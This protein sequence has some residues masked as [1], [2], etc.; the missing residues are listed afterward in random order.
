VHD[1]PKKG[2]ERLQILS[3]ELTF[4]ECVNILH[5]GRLIFKFLLT[6]KVSEYSNDNELFKLSKWL[7]E[8][9]GEIKV[10]LE[11]KEIIYEGDNAS[12]REQKLKEVRNE[13]E[14]KYRSELDN[15]ITEQ[16]TFG[17]HGYTL[18]YIKNYC[19][20]LYQKYDSLISKEQNRSLLM[21]GHCIILM[22][23]AIKVLKRCHEEQNYRAFLSF[24]ELEAFLSLPKEQ[25]DLNSYVNYR[26][27]M[28]M[29]A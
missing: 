12:L 6:L 10:K 8:L 19:Y 13:Y 16:H 26:K 17:E 27:K 5:Y 7:M 23:E 18:D 21:L 2:D 22:S 15:Y 24:K 4:K 25:I 29:Y 28:L 20:N 1:R 14:K 11:K 3:G 9:L